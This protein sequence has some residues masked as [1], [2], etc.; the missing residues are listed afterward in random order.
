ADGNHMLF[1]SFSTLLKNL[2]RKDLESLWKLVKERFEKTEPKSYS[3]D[4]LLKTLKTMYE[5]LDVEASVWR[6][7]KGRYGLAKRYPLTHFTLE[8]MLNNVILEVEEES[9]MS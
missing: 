9:E 7:Q 6:D 3:D 4:Y 8:Q 2:E 5:Q 1:L